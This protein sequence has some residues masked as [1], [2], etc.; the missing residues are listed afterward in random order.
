[1]GTGSRWGAVVAIGIG[2]GTA[3]AAS[4]GAAGFALGLA[5]AFLA[6]TILPRLR[7]GPDIGR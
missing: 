3:L 4:L 1:M 7:R 2:L 5:V 6:F